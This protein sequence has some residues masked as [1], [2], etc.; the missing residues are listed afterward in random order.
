MLKSPDIEVRGGKS[1]GDP[2]LPGEVE[3]EEHAA[4]L[5]R[6]ARVSPR[7]RIEECFSN[8]VLPSFKGTGR[9]SD[10]VGSGSE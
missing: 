4:K 6:S 8:I 1:G 5:A 2:G 10:G 9:V 3:S 7:L